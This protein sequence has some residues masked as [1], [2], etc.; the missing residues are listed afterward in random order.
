MLCLDAVSSGQLQTQL[1]SAFGMYLR[2]LQTIACNVHS[3]PK[4]PVP[5]LPN[6]RMRGRTVVV[7]ISRRPDPNRTCLLI[8]VLR[9]G[10][11]RH[12]G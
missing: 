12:S 6:R 11:P 10:T 5:K 7:L 2:T 1:I 4:L 9:A 8:R 3:L